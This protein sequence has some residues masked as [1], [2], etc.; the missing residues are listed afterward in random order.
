MSYEQLGTS[1]LHYQGE[2]GALYMGTLSSFMMQH[3]E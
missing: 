1:S 3:V 2:L